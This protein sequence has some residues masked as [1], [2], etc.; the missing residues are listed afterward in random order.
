MANK[1]KPKERLSPTSTFAHLSDEFIDALS[2]PEL[3]D[4][5]PER[6][7]EAVRRRVNALLYALK[8]AKKERY[9]PALEIRLVRDAHRAVL[10]AYEL[11]M[12]DGEVFYASFRKLVE[13]LGYER[14]DVG[15][16]KPPD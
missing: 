5:I 3:P 12:S 7:A 15:F 1:N 2:I 11:N 13:E 4:N 8:V 9:V 10:T 14:T 16:S 6:L